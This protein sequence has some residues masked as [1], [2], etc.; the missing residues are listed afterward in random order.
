MRWLNDFDTKD[1]IVFIVTLVV[2]YF[3]K[4]L[5][6]ANLNAWS[7]ISKDKNLAKEIGK[8]EEKKRK[9]DKVHI[10]QRISEKELKSTAWF[11]GP[12][13]LLAMIVR[14]HKIKK[15]MFLLGYCCRCSAGICLV[16][17]VLFLYLILSLPYIVFYWPS[18]RHGVMMHLVDWSEQFHFR[19]DL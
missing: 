15:P 18:A 7:K 11:G 8:K 14:R 3:V 2:L 1:A 19:L 10:P 5:I 13:G 6:E 12:S 17:I 4:F 16:L 9:G